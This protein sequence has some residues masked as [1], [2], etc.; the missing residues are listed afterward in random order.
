MKLRDIL[1]KIRA[2]GT[3]WAAERSLDYLKMLREY[4]LELLLKMLPPRGRLLEIGAGT[5]WQASILESK[6]YDVSA[7]D[8]PE[9]NYAE[10][11]VR[12]VIQ[13]D[14]R[15]L[16]FEDGSFDIVFSSNVLEHIPHVR[17]FQTE[18]HR[19]LKAD[20][21]VIHIL[22]SSN[23][24]IWANIAHVMRQWTFP[25][26]HGEHAANA[27]SEIYYFSRRWWTTLFQETDW[28]VEVQTSNGL[29]YSGYSLLGTR[30]AIPARRRLGR[31][32]G[33][34]CEIYLLRPSARDSSK[35]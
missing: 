8:I 3:F 33:D 6:G 20:G 26:P 5:G 12:E 24:R 35:C 13:Y 11:C 9:S 2:V 32:L 29:F 19:V 10:N 21:C 1:V 17:E 34:S 30:L 25:R 27:F 14:G 31:M 7:I 16:P 18:I 15:H 4:E 23:W 28:I 22:P